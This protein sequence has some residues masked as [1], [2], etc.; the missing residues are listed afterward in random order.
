M[1]ENKYGEADIPPSSASRAPGRN[2]RD[3]VVGRSFTDRASLLVLEQLA[4]TTTVARYVL[5][6]GE[7]SS[8]KQR[9]AQGSLTAVEC[10][11]QVSLLQA[12]TPIAQ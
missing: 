9:A 10:A 3:A 8:R 11:E 1:E 12:L 7:I 2:Y 4:S 6:S 5:S